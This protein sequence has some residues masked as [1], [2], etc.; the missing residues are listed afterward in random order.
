MEWVGVCTCVCTGLSRRGGV[1]LGEPSV[2]YTNQ[3]QSCH[4]PLSSRTCNLPPPLALAR[5]VGPGRPASPACSV[6]NHDWKQRPPTHPPPLLLFVSPKTHLGS[7]FIFQ[8]DHEVLTLSENRSEAV[9]FMRNK[10]G[11]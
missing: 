5:P 2:N 6:L 3:H 9:D 10:E 11:K 8:F 7:L 4:C 1:G